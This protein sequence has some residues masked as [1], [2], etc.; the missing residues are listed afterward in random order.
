MTARQVTVS[1]TQNLDSRL[2]DCTAR[3]AGRA[4]QSL[5]VAS[6][7]ESLSRRRGDSD[8]RPAISARSSPSS[9]ILRGGTP[10][11]IRCRVVRPRRWPGPGR[12]R[13]LRSSGSAFRCCGRPLAG[14]LLPSPATRRACP[15]CKPV[16]GQ[17]PCFSILFLI[18]CRNL[19]CLC[20][21]S[22]SCAAC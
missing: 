15:T 5:Q 16:Q 2:A 9:R 19:C 6:D 17:A 21:R 12:L 1:P 18:G 10:F 13:L 20:S 11:F 8:D 7:S 4:V 3:S 14:L 22:L